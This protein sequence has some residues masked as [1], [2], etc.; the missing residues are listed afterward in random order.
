ML[1]R[2]DPVTFKCQMTEAEAKKSTLPSQAGEKGAAAPAGPRGCRAGTGRAGDAHARQE[3]AG[4]MARPRCL[5]PRGG[6]GRCVAQQNPAEHGREQ[7][8]ERRCA[9]AQ[10]P[11]RRAVGRRGELARVTVSAFG[12]VKSLPAFPPRPPALSRVPRDSVARVL[13]G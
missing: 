7:G 12:T 9:S 3:Q 11:W 8:A 5:G 4:G 10:C 13:M 6:R 2:R 1:A